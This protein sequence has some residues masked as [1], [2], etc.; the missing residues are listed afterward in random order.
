MTLLEAGSQLGGKLCTVTLET[1]LGKAVIDGGAE[2]FV[3][4]KPEAYQLALEL[5]LQAAMQIETEVCLLT[6]EVDFFG[7]IGP[8]FNTVGAR[9]GGV[10][11]GPGA[12]GGRPCALRSRG[13]KCEGKC[14]Q[15]EYSVS[16]WSQETHRNP[17][18]GV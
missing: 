12:V 10:G 7:R 15:Q 17:E 11:G 5:G 14:E 9:L 18:R 16:N 3:T 8:G 4:R 13:P 1:A 6:N 2:S